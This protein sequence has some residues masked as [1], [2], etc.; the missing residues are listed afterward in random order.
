[1]RIISLL[2]A[3]VLVNALLLAPQWVLAGGPGPL[4]IAMEAWLIVGVFGLLPRRRRTSLLAAATAVVLILV[5]VLAFAD[6]A[7][8]ESLARPL[9]LYLDVHLLS[10]IDSLLTGALGSVAATLVLLGAAV[11]F[12]LVGWLVAR[13]LAP[14]ADGPAL[15]LRVMG[16]TLI[17]VFC[18]GV[19]GGREPALTKRMAL[20]A[21]RVAT[22]QTRLFLRMLSERERFEQE[23]ADVPAGYS[24]LPGLLG[25]LQGRDV[26][27]AFMES[28]GV[29]ALYDPLYSG[30]I[31]PR[32][33]D[34]TTRTRSSGLHLATGT[35]VA[36]T[37]G[38]QSWFAHGSVI[39]GAWLNNQLRYDLLLASKRETL[40]DDFRHAGHRT[41]A[42][43]PAITLVW[44][45]GER[46]G[47]D[48]IHAH[49]NIGYA[50]PPLNW[51]T[52]PDQF[53]WSF[54]QHSVRTSTDSGG[55]A[56][57]GARPVFAE[58]GLI[59]SHA[60]WTPILPVL[61]DWDS[62]EDGSIF[63]SWE[64]AGER[65]KE[66]WQD[67]DRIREHYALSLD[68]ALNAMIGFAERYVDDRTL[69]IVIGDH[70]PAPLITGENASRAV[71]VHVISGDAELVQPFLDWGFEPGAL[72]NPDH[73][74]P[75]M[76]AFRDWFVHAYSEPS[77]AGV[78]KVDDH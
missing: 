70:Q 44:P 12:V 24:D 45:E 42:I 6:A 29:S 53:T 9:N 13:L 64:H 48:E 62:I 76:A 68:Y 34:L 57:G 28:Y 43:M 15:G 46:L 35:M 67:L 25:R 78:T 22:D 4:W 73:R 54:L 72:P 51:V 1:M 56:A 21:V 8:R 36:P 69:L 75:N 38:G 5:V 66:L 7:T 58:L 39:S 17:G 32:L 10:S 27:L 41:V 20:P 37:Q 61:D 49:K 14:P 77:P 11:G 47:Y 40:I 19:A 23:L 65:P 52:M 18:L 2:V 60:P 55:G 50:G 59:S 33:D 16:V 31:L 3:L 74:T 30:V 71:P 26:L 63:A